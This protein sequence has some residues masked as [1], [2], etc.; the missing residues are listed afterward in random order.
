MSPE[1]TSHCGIKTGRGLGFLFFFFFLARTVSP[2]NGGAKNEKV[3]KLCSARESCWR[4]RL[5]KR[6]VEEEKSER[7][8]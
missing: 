7:L 2:G 8:R 1:H 3:W 5:E 6:G 4:R